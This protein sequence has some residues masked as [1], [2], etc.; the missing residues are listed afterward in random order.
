MISFDLWFL[1]N[2]VIYW[3]NIKIKIKIENWI[4]KRRHLEWSAFRQLAM[5][6]VQK[7]LTLIRATAS[8][9]SFYTCST[10][11]ERVPFRSQHNAFCSSRLLADLPALIPTVVSAVQKFFH[12]GLSAREP[13]AKKIDLRIMYLFFQNIKTARIQLHRSLRAGQLRKTKRLNLASTRFR[14]LVR[15][16]PIRQIIVQ[17]QRR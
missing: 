9:T 10:M 5:P 7:W 14:N 6:S 3:D 17:S 13:R 16:P 12:L 2:W 11:R 1:S 4:K 8:K 15:L